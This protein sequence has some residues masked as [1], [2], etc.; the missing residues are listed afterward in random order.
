MHKAL[1][2]KWRP[3]KFSEVVGQQVPVT[4]L[5]N[6]VKAK[7]V[8]PG[9]VFYGS[10]GSGKT[11]LAR[12][13]AKALNCSN[14]TDDICGTC[15]SCRAIAEGAGSLAYI[16]QDAASHGNVDDV[17]ELVKQLRYE[18]PGVTHRVV[19]LDECHMMSNAAWNAMLKVI[20][21]PPPHVVFIFVTTEVRKVLETILSRCFA[22]PFQKI[23]ADQIVGQLTMIAKEEGIQL[24]VT[25]TEAIARRSEGR[26]RDAVTL[27]E[28][29][30][31][32]SDGKDISEDT[33]ALVGVCGQDVYAKFVDLIGS[34]QTKAGVELFRHWLNSMGPAEFLRGLEDYL[35]KL[36]LVENGFTAVSVVPTKTKMAWGD[37]NECIGRVWEMQDVT[38]THYSQ[39]RIEAMLCRLFLRFGSARPEPGDKIPPPLQTTGAHSL[40]SNGHNGNGNGH[41]GHTKPAAVKSMEDMKKWLG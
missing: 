2:L 38:R 9:L 31:V 8:F 7:R 5:R 14:Y 39:P 20:E 19:C 36:F 40:V 33:L 23:K 11:S 13:Y 37:L 6:I 26:L 28:Q 18:V 15:D 12:I 16:E 35:H 34:G 30:W 29:L 22:L 3:S 27:L 24:P 1:A 10:A 25:V 21:E 4:V 17:H 32:L 41:N